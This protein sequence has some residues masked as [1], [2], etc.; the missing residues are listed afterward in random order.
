MPKSSKHINL[1]RSARS[2]KKQNSQLDLSDLRGTFIAFIIIA[3]LWA[4]SAVFLYKDPNRGTFGDMFGAINSLFSGLALAALI[5]AGL[6]QRKEISL[7]RYEISFTRNEMA[8]QRVQMDKQIEQLSE[9]LQISHR[10]ALESTFFQI[11]GLLNKIIE[12]ITCKNASNDL[13]KGRDC[14]PLIYENLTNTYK[15]NQESRSFDNRLTLLRATF[16]RV[17]NEHQTHLIQYYD[18]LS[19]LIDYVEKSLAKDKELYFNLI[20]AQWSDEEAAIL[21]YYCFSERGKGH[22]RH[23][24]LKTRMLAFIN[25]RFLLSPLDRDALSELN[26][27]EDFDKK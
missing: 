9:Q 18:T 19:H 4:G 25:I 1:Y 2:S 27:Y 21:F 10:Q 17:W 5:Y 3:M 6:Q 14:L 16:Q 15:L 23:Q 26:A 12:S 13:I 11:L 24:I 20:I 22:M 8:E 7:Q